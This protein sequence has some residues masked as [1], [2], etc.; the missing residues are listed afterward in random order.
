MEAVLE[1]YVND[2]CNIFNFKQEDNST[3][4]CQN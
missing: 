2:F 4:P 3:V 1:N